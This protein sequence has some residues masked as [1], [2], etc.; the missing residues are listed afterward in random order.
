MLTS[1]DLVWG[2]IN[3]E[4]RVTVFYDVL[5]W[6]SEVAS[7]GQNPKYIARLAAALRM[8]AS[9]VDQA[10]DQGALISTF[11][12]NVVFSKFYQPEELWW[13]LQGAATIQFGLAM[14]GFFIRGGVTIGPLHHDHRIVFGPALNRAYE[15]E[16]K[17]AVYPRIIIDPAIL[18]RLPINLPYVE[19]DAEYTFID[20]FKPAFFEHVQ[21]SNPVQDSTL[22]A[23]N[24]LHGTSITKSPVK[25]SGHTALYSILERLRLKL[26]ASPSQYE[27]EKNAWLFDR[28]ATRLKTTF[29][30]TDFPI[31]PLTKNDG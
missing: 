11:S 22:E 10:G 28:I 5:G 20:P 6:K 2:D 27:W 12:D 24:E 29:S 26:K 25:I 19:R 16:S 21:Q 4:E 8:F 18:D 15:L 9:H 17:E 13:T 30:A 14:I 1:N 23:F 3:Y 7:A 31:E